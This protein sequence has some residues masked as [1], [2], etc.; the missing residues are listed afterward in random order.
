[1]LFHLFYSLLPVLKRE[2]P[3]HFRLGNGGGSHVSEL[4]AGTYGV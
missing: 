4:N 1:M 3:L 2:N